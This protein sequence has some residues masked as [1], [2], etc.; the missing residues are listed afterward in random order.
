MEQN[1]QQSELQQP[2]IKQ[3]CLPCKQKL[4]ELDKQILEKKK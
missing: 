1:K 4:E 3:D 2:P